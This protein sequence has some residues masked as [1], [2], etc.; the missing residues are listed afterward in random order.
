MT[1]LNAVRRSRWLAGSAMLEPAG[2]SV[3]ADRPGP[4]PSSFVGE[5]RVHVR[6]TR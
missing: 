5:S 3:Q 4:T 1:S 6:G 2:N